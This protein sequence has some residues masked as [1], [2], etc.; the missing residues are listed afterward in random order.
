MSGFDVL[1]ATEISITSFISLVQVIKR[2][3]DCHQ[4][5]KKLLD[6]LEDLSCRIQTKISMLV[7]I[8]EAS[9]EPCPFF[10]SIVQKITDVSDKYSKIHEEINSR[11][12]IVN[13]FK[14]PDLA[15]K[16]AS[17][18]GNLESYDNTLDTFGFVANVMKSKSSVGAIEN[19]RH[20]PYDARSIKSLRI[21]MKRKEDE[22]E[23]I[24]VRAASQDLL[25]NESE[26]RKNFALGS[27][28]YTG[29]LTKD[30][31]RAA[32]YFT[33]AYAYGVWEAAFY[34][35]EI[36]YNGLGVEKNY[37]VAYKF[38]LVGAEN[39]HGKSLTMVGECLC[40]GY[41]TE[42][43]YKR[44]GY[45]YKRGSD[46]GCLKGSFFYG[47]R[48]FHGTSG[49]PN[50]KAG[51]RLLVKASRG[52]NRVANNELALCYQHGIEVG[53]RDPKKAYE[54]LQDAYDS[55]MKFSGARVAH[56]YERGFGVKRDEKRAAEI[57][58]EVYTR[59]GEEGLQVQ[60]Y[61]GM[62]FILGKGV[63]R[64]VPKGFDIIKESCV[65][66]V[67][68]GWNALGDC[69]RHGYGVDRNVDQAI[70]NYNKAISAN[71]GVRAL[72]DAHMSLADM[73]EKGEG[74][75]RV[76]KQAAHHFMYAAERYNADAQFKVALMY[77]VGEGVDLNVDRAVMYF[78]LSARGG[79]SHA[80]LKAE[81]Y[82]QKGHGIQNSTTLSIEDVQKVADEGHSGALKLLRKMSLRVRRRATN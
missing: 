71:L 39:D 75:P 51:F 44:A 73:Y 41:G 26:G 55:G 24:G 68:T 6:E 48:L 34:L 28:Y 47:F 58:R 57:Y 53:T 81:E 45:F 7:G 4:E 19:M 43:N 64:N 79:N 66:N 50:L 20:L 8:L 27:L 77:E 60:G 49:P 37:A 78:K 31:T 69:Y 3:S 70:W 16:L 13:F 14:A 38:Y 35:G 12:G 32:E 63:E 82:L 11:Y 29:E 2:S 23:E 5:V 56:Y 36:Y 1:G 18:S 25:S 54:L 40:F 33:T 10:T 72:V 74:L 17:I 30:F 61:Y 80:F 59:G 21:D 62:C 76:P 22:G 52:G 65:A 67:A 15:G 46:A 42:R 9:Y